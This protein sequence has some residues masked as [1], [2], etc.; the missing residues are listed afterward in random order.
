ML[1]Y[2]KVANHDIVIIIICE[3]CFI[4]FLK[5]YT[6]FYANLIFILLKLVYIFNII[7]LVNTDILLLKPLMI[8]L[9]YI[10]QAYVA[11]KACQ[12]MMEG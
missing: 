5:L 4:Y 11:K 8:F 7:L 9:N 2:N 3:I 6:N 1:F 10:S 12:K